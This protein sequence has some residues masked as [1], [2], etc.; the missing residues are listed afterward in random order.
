VPLNLLVVVSLDNLLELQLLRILLQVFL[1]SL[2]HL[3]QTHLHQQAYLD[4]LPLQL[5]VQ[6]HLLLAHSGSLLSHLPQLLLQVYSANPIPPQLPPTQQQVVCLDN[7]LQQE[8][9]V[10][11]LPQL[12]RLLAVCLV[13]NQ[14]LVP[15]TNHL[16]RDKTC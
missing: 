7:L 8:P 6:I 13:K 11:L 9:S 1:G 16:H 15:S 2:T 5:I 10:K 14:L 4:N 12:A 3:L